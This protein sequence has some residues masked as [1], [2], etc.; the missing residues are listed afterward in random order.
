[1][2]MFRVVC[3]GTNL[4]GLCKTYDEAKGDADK[5]NKRAAEEKARDGHHR[6]TAVVVSVDVIERR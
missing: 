3:G 4:G 2:K 1:M 5:F 6:D